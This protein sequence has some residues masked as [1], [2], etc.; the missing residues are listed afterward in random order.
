M[1]KKK[2]NETNGTPEVTPGE[3]DARTLSAS[4]L[5][6]LF[7]SY[8][9]A[10]TQVDKVRKDLEALL[11]ARSEIVEQIASGAGRGPFGYKGQVLTVVCRT[12]KSTGQ[13]TWFFKGP[14]KNDLTEVS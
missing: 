13:S 2:A 3:I 12:A 5:K 10:T 11:S 1:A 8:D 6:A 14:S 9:Q 7:K 4:E